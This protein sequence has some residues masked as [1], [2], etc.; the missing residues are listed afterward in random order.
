LTERRFERAARKAGRIL[1]CSIERPPNAVDVQFFGGQAALN[2]N[3]SLLVTWCKKHSTW[4]RGGYA[5]KT[6]T[7]IDILAAVEAVLEGSQFV[8]PVC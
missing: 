6:R 1:P 5:L 4:G 2:G 3:R 8:S 7:A